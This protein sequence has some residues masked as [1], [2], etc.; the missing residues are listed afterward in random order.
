MKKETRT[1]TNER[2]AMSSKRMARCGHWDVT[3]RYF[4]CVSCQ[5]VLPSDEKGGW[6]YFSE[7]DE[8]EELC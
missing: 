2:D 1:Y 5:P 7:L 8:E 6:E 3:G 4:K